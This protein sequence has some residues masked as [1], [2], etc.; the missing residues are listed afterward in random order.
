MGCGLC[1]HPIF[2]SPSRF[3]VFF[4]AFIVNP[5]TARKEWSFGIWS[6]ECLSSVWK[7]SYDYLTLP[8]VE[9]AFL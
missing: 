2:R 7:I 5:T 1:P 8:D 6:F 9:D 3:L 4:S